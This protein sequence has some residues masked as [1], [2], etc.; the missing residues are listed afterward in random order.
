MDN[1]IKIILDE[2]GKALSTWMT[3]I[4]KILP[5]ANLITNQCHISLSRTLVLKYHWIDSFVNSLRKLCQSTDGFSLDI[6]DLKIYTNEEKTRTFLGIQCHNHDN[7]LKNFMDSFSKILD[8][9]K[10]P[11]FYQVKKPLYLF[12]KK[13]IISFCFFLQSKFVI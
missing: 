13:V 12:I 1:V 7:K 8:D 4:N 11:Q 3:S 6:G 2:P 10:L 5:N 9:Y